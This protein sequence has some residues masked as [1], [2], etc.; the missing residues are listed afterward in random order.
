MVSD[1]LMILSRPARL[2]ECLE[3]DPGTFYNLLEVEEHVINQRQ[4]DIEMGDYIRN[5]LGVAE[6]ATE[7]VEVQPVRKV[8]IILI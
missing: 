8:F 4:I 2:L 5:K 1:V 3:F 7:P 6:V